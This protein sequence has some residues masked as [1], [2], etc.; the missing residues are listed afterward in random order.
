[1][2]TEA[3]TGSPRPLIDAL[4]RALR[5]QGLTYAEVA[6]RM[7]LSEAS[8]KRLLSRG[9]MSLEQLLQLAAIAGTDLAELTRQAGVD[10]QAPRQ[11]SLE[12]ERALAEDS[13]LLMLFHLLVAGRSVA[14]IAR[15]F[16]L[17]GP[18]CTQLL[19]KLDRL[20]LI[21]WLPQDRVRL[22]VARDF[23]WR[24][25]GPIRRRYGAQVLREFL[26]DRFDGDQALLRFEVRELSDAS[27]DVI[28]RRLQ[29]LASEIADMAELDAELPNERK[30]SVG[31][32]LALRPW[33]FSIAEA[34][35]LKAE[36]GG[37][38]SSPAFAGA[39]R[40]R[41]AS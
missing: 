25:D 26:R 31:V 6:K 32:A 34:L 33:V 28:R 41:A 9:R 40:G 17:R 20:A 37:S 7:R 11:L 1:M 23:S 27:V 13:R 36:P 3:P 8:I 38:E 5:R 12:Q 39:K 29:R 15:E 18:E 24:S 22:R 4:K 30:H 2:S 21:E 10:R 14:G 19:A 35:K 16:A